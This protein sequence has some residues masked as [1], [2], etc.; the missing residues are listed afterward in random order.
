MKL[1]LCSTCAPTCPECRRRLEDVHVFCASCR[2]RKGGAVT[3]PRKTKSSRQNIAKT[4]NMRLKR[5]RDR[6]AVA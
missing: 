3:S 2:G 1:T 5:R 4:P 6:R